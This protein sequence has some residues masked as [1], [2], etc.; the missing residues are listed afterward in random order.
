MSDASVPVPVAP[1]SELHAMLAQIERD[2]D[3]HR[4]NRLMNDPSIYPHVRG[5]HQDKL[6]FSRAIGDQTNGNAA[7]VGEHG[8]VLFQQMQPGLYEAHTFVL[9]EGRGAWAV[10]MVR[11]TLHW[12]FTHSI[13]VEIYTRVPKG[14]LAALGLVRA[15]HGKRQFTRK[16]GW[17]LDFDPIPA[18]IYTLH[19][20]DWLAHAPG[21]VERGQW[22]HRRLEEEFAQHGHTEPQHE[23][24]IVHDRYVGAAVE[25]IFGGMPQKGVLFYNRWAVMAGY[26]PVSIVGFNP[27]TIDIRNALITVRGYDFKVQTCRVAH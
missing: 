21:L 16:D 14:N 27:L 8:G 13:C 12:M 26:A 5:Y 11:A 2:T 10:A 20:C 18:D 1:I 19:I 6:D 17:V 25:M 9:P 15:I 3:A 24:D 22:F 4:V 7:L 23:D